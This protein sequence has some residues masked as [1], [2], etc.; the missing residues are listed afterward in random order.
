MPGKS[1]TVS[2]FWSNWCGPGAQ[3]TGAPGTLPDAIGLTLASRTR[4]T[5]PLIQA[6]RCDAPDSPSTVSVGPF[7]PTVRRLPESSRLPLRAAIVGPR[8]VRVNP[9][10]RAFRVHRGQLLR[11]EVALTNTGRSAFRFARSS[12]PIYIEELNPSAPQVYV[13]NCRPAGLF[14]PRATVLFAME[15]RVPATAP[16]GIGSLTWELAPRTYEAPF[17]PAALWVVP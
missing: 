8:P 2:L 3:P 16:L 7:T 15:I 1:A 10:V 12:C 4:I 6:P 14:A 5:V 11:Y 13:L 17:A 9:G